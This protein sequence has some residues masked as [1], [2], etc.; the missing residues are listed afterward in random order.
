[1][2]T[3][4]RCC[5]R[6]MTTEWSS[7]HQIRLKTRGR[8]PVSK[9]IAVCAFPCNSRHHSHKYC[10]SPSA[11]QFR[12]SNLIQPLQNHLPFGIELANPPSK[13]YPHKP[14]NRTLIVPSPLPTLRQDGCRRIMREF[15]PPPTN[16]LCALI[17][18]HLTANIS[19]TSRSSPSSKPSAHV[20]WPS[21][22]A[23][24]PSC[25]PSSAP[26]SPSLTSSSPALPAD[27]AADVEEEEEAL[28]SPSFGV[29]KQR[30]RQSQAVDVCVGGGAERDFQ[31]L[32]GS[33]LV[34]TRVW[35]RIGRV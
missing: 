14:S 30:R 26:S 16:H 27:V 33:E 3:Q 24:A 31:T 2:E 12:S 11:R 19:S 18:Q 35:H 1:M 15:L 8:F 17:H 29:N 6:T 13:H 22:T 32:H 28:C 10:S 25:K 7:G 20:S 5:R 23:S 21:L 4:C 34:G 9:E